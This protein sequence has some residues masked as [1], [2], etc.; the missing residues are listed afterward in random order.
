VVA[1]GSERPRELPAP[2]EWLPLA[3]LTE[4]VALLFPESPGPRPAS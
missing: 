4:L 1:H 2:V 3:R